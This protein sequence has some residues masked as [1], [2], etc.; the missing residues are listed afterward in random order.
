MTL[1]AKVYVDEDVDVL[2]ATLLLAQGIDA[3]TTREQG[4]F[5]LGLE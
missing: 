3:T 5:G 1:F 4:L 2:G